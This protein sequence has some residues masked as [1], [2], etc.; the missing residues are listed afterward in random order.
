MAMRY[1]KKIKDFNRGSFSGVIPKQKSTARAVLFVLYCN[2]QNNIKQGT[3]NKAMIPY[4]V[5]SP[6][7]IEI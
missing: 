2:G 1:I 4:E 6:F 7:I 3:N 5:S